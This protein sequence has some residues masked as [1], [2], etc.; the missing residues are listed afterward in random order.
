MPGATRCTWARGNTPGHVGMTGG[1]GRNG[2]GEGMQARRHV[3]MW[4]WNGNQEE[5]GVEVC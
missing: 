2:V 5:G 1:R 4:S 3:G